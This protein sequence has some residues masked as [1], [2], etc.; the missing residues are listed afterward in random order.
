MSPAQPTALLATLFLSLLPACAASTPPPV[1]D[2]AQAPP[3]LGTPAPST[4]APSAPSPVEPRD[5]SP[6]ES[7]VL[8]K[9]Q[10][11]ADPARV[12]LG[13]KVQ[14]VIENVDDHAHRFYHMGGSNG[15]A[16]FRWHLHLVDAQGR[17]LDEDFLEP[18]RKCTTVMVPPRWIE[19]AP[20]K[21]VSLTLDTAREWYANDLSAREAVAGRL[22]PGTYTVVVRAPGL[23][24]QTK[25]EITAPPA[26]R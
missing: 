4:S 9:V 25:V 1:T 14:I 10:L 21:P 24:L 13:G 17:A 16:A 2:P 26:K 12:E 8:A 15:C 6:G 19:I 20:G 18:G 22:A 23:D 7:P 3:A 11:R 5:P